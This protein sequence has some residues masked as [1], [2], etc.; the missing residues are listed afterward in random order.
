MVILAPLGQSASS[1]AINDED[2]AELPRFKGT[3]CARQLK[4][5]RESEVYPVGGDNENPGSAHG[6]EDDGAARSAQRRAS[7]LRALEQLAGEFSA[8]ADG[9]SEDDRS[10]CIQQMET[11]FM[12]VQQQAPPPAPAHLINE[13]FLSKEATAGVFFA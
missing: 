2:V 1:T 10:A 7:Q 11:M 13:A 8:V 5:A 6:L 12:E 3:Y 9:L 4:K